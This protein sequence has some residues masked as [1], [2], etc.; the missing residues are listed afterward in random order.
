M[1]TREQHWTE[2]AE[3]EGE[4][5]SEGVELA[6]RWERHSSEDKARARKLFGMSAGDVAQMTA[7]VTAAEKDTPGLSE[8]EAQAALDSGEFMYWTSAEWRQKVPDGR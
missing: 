1:N 7:R 8:S 3:V 5:Q 2:I 4:A 6:E